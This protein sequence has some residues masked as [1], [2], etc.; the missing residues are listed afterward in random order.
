MN[1]TKTDFALYPITSDEAATCSAILVQDDSA[2]MLLIPTHHISP[3]GDMMGFR[4]E[5]WA[6]RRGES[7]PIMRTVFFGHT[8]TECWTTRRPL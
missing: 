4:Y 5:C 6:H 1:W 8:A 2:R 7:L 3:Q